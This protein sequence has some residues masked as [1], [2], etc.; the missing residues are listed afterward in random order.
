MPK[1]TGSS[2]STDPQDRLLTQR[3]VLQFTGW[4]S[5][6]TLR[7]KLKL[8]LL[9]S[10]IRLAGGTLRWRLSTLSAW[11]STQPEQHY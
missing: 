2:S 9:P 8:G 6:S 10:P 11:A 5:R 4:R 7:R 1:P 3:E